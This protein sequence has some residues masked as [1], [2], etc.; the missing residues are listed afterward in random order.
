MSKC[1]L[2]LQNINKGK[3]GDFQIFISARMAGIDIAIQVDDTGGGQALITDGLLCSIMR[4]LSRTA[5]QT[6]LA[7]VIERVVPENEVKI[8]WPKLF[9]HFKDVMD[10][11]RKKCII[12]IDRESTKRRVAD[13]VGQLVKVDREN[14]VR[15]LLVMPWNYVIRDFE[16]DSEERSR[17]WEEE[18]NKDYD[19]RIDNLEK[20]MDRKHSSNCNEG[21]DE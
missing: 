16:S 7:D 6:Q 5:S 13:I 8:A 20:K 17:I 15:E 9:T 12:D 11:S 3:K 10:P 19:A 4:A 14:D 21:Y 18:K 1:T 2:I